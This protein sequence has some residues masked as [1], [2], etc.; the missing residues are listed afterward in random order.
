MSRVFVG[1]GS[2]EGHRLDN[3]SRAIGLLA[4]QPKVRVV[5]MAPIYETTP[6]G[7]PPQDDFFN[8]VVEVETDLPPEQLLQ[9]T[10]AIERQM[11]RATPGVRWGPRPIDLDILL[12]DDR[13]VHA[14][15]LMIP[16]A[17]LH[18]RR[19][20]LEPLM[21]LAPQLIHPVLR[22]TIA[23]LFAQLPEAAP[24]PVGGD[25]ASSGA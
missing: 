5:Q 2:N 6:V 8:T 13:T 23:E 11:G 24:A 3:I 10:Q 19:F 25:A 17:M 12:Y 4:L 7:G 21:Q 9:V 14:D 16:H 18:R 15:S 22:Q 20:V 1:I